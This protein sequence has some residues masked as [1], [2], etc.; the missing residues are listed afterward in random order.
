L[1]QERWHRFNM[2]NTQHLRTSIQRAY[3][4][5][6][7]R[8]QDEHPFPIGRSFAESIGYPRKLLESL[9]SISVDA[10]AGA[11]N[12]AIFA[13][14]PEGAT[15]LDLGCGS[16]LDTL[17]AARR[18]GPKGRV[19]GIDFSDAMLVRARRAVE[20]EALDNVELYLADAEII[21]VEDK[22]IDVA[23]INGIFNLNPTRDAIFNE[24][25][26]VVRLGGAVYASELIL[27]E[28]LTHN[29]CESETDWLA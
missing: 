2:D 12:V 18:T 9:P 15:V 26:R 14:I 28:P 3:T 1:K 16:A 10:F 25:A 23:I 7:Q 4:E 5:A 21:P 27:R 20:Q 13:D 6:A 8:P 17:I 29:V 11:S 22:V 24:L 19:I